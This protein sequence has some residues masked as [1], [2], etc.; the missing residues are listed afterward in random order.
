M[1]ITIPPIPAGV[2]VLLAFFGPYAVA[3]LN[4]ALPFANTP[5]QKRLV[6]ILVAIALAALVLILYIAI[7]GD[8]PAGWP[9]WIL[10]SVLVLSA[11]YALVTKSSAS[12]LE[13]RTAGGREA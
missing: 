5:L 10:L 11:S 4:G 13:E 3:L 8:V 12:R 1:E 7:T 6:S 9:A 2:L